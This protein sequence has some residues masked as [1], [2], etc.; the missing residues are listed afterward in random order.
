MAMTDFF[1]DVPSRVA[2]AN[3]DPA[4]GLG[5]R[6]YDPERMVAGKRMEDQLRI[7][8]CYWH[9][10]NC[11]GSDIFGDGTMQRCVSL[12]ISPVDLSAE[13]KQSISYV[14]RPKIYGDVQCGLRPL[15]DI[16]SFGNEQFSDLQLPCGPMTAR[17]GAASPHSQP[18]APGLLNTCRLPADFS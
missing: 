8:V 7:A 13:F 2:Y 18:Q 5:Y 14:H 3:E 9:S 16:G 12:V 6:V 4:D 10:F 17:V 11:P 1:T 15:I